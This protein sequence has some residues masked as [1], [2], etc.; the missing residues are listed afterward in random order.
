MERPQT[1]NIA[2]NSL[3][4]IVGIN[5][6]LLVG[7]TLLINLASQGH[8]RG[9]AVMILMAFAVGIHAAVCLLAMIYGFVNKN[10]PLG[11]AWLLSGGIVLVVGFSACLGTAGL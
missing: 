1:K 2:M 5:L 4:K 10:K 6:I 8:E 11:R 9:L 7:Y 3:Q